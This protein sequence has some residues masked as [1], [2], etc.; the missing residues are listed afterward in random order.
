M[1]WK[2]AQSFRN[3]A[4]LQKFRR[5]ADA[6]AQTWLYQRCHVQSGSALSANRRQRHPRTCRVLHR[7][8]P[9]QRRR[10]PT[11]RCPKALR[12]YGGEQRR[13]RME[14]ARCRARP[15]DAFPRRKYAHQSRRTVSSTMVDRAGHYSDL[16]VEGIATVLA[17]ALAQRFSASPPS[18]RIFRGGLNKPTLRTIIDFI[19]ANPDADLSLARLSSLAGLSHFYFCRQFKRSIGRTVHEYVLQVRI[20]TAKYLLASTNL[21]IPEVC[22][23]SGITNLSHFTT[24]FRKYVGVTPLLFR[25]QV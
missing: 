25:R 2:L 13:P 5:G 17:A 1:F 12:R 16:V 4:I 22:Y 9:P 10:D 23:R 6:A 24:A 20:D 7:R 15:P 11:C 19:H 8:K 18:A 3:R 21:S 14:L